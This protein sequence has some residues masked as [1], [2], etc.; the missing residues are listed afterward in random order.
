MAGPLVPLLVMF[1]WGAHLFAEMRTPP[2]DAEVIHVQAKRWM[3]TTQHENGSRQKN[4]LTV[5]LGLPIKLVMRSED[6]IHD[7]YVPAFRTKQDVLPGRFTEQ[8][9][10]ATKPGVYQMY[11]SEYC[12]AEHSQMRGSVTVLK[13]EEYDAWLTGTA[14]DQPPAV[15]G[16]KLFQSEGCASCHGQRAPTLNGVYGTQQPLINGGSAMADETYLRESILVPAA[17]IVAGYSAGN[18]PSYRERLTEEQVEDIIAYL[19]TLTPISTPKDQLPAASQPV[20][21]PINNGGRP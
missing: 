20:V 17:K 14:A 5:P 1:Y 19:K 8:W 7:F 4:E 18:M 15:V 21:E 6:V 13:P 16:A 11:C 10:I 9:F 3:W 2:S 12:G